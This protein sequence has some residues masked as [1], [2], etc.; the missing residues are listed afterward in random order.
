MQSEVNS[1]HQ[2]VKSS[3]HFLRQGGE[4]LAISEIVKSI[5]S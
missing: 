1:V 3:T 5:L 2:V 4:V